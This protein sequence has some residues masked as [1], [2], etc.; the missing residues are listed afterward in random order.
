M[1]PLPASSTILLEFTMD[2]NN[3]LQVAGFVNDQAVT[4]NACNNQ[5]SCLASDFG[6]SLGQSVKVTSTPSF[7]SKK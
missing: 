6:S 3:N 1:L 5:N 7:C 4:L 2:G